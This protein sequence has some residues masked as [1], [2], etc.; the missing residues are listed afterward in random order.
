MRVFIKNNIFF[1]MSQR[2]INKQVSI[3]TI[4]TQKV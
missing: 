4:K 1:D 3:F 2:I